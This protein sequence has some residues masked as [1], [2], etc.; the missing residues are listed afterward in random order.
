MPLHLSLQQLPFQP[1]AEEAEEAEGAEGAEQRLLQPGAE[2]DS[3][4]SLIGLRFESG[5]CGNWLPDIMR[6]STWQQAR[7]QRLAPHQRSA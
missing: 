7:F 5:G 4:P 6:G 2:A 1:G 3:L